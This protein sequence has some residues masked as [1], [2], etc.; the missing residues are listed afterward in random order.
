MLKLKT[1]TLLAI[2]GV[3]LMLLSLVCSHLFPFVITWIWG[4]SDGG[5]RTTFY[6]YSAYAQI[7][8]DV[9]RFVGWSL[10][11]LFF[12]TIYIKQKKE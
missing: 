9:L 6:I 4:D 11:G 5:M 3:G 12:V 10:I 8:C 1:A 2:I 7:F